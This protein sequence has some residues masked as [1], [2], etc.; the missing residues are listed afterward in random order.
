M[1][2]ATQTCV[3]RIAAE[4]ISS[5]FNF[6]FDY[7]LMNGEVS[8]A[9]K[10]SPG[11]SNI[12]AVYYVC[13]RIRHVLTSFVLLHFSLMA[14]F[15]TGMYHT[16][17]LS[18]STFS[19]FLLLILILIREFLLLLR[20]VWCLFTFVWYVFFYIGFYRLLR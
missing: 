6:T 15:V 4:L 7:L 3:I 17:F 14:S 13:T 18:V 1:L 2:I 5:R 12:I 8:S 19:F 20:K 9:T 11:A 10:L 16:V